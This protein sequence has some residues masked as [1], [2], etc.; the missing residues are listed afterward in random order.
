V[1]IPPAAGDGTTLRLVLA[2]PM[3]RV[4]KAPEMLVAAE[5][6]P[7]L[8]AYGSDLGIGAEREDPAKLRLGEIPPAARSAATFRR[9]L[10][11]SSTLGCSCASLN[12]T[13]CCNSGQ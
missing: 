13:L 1:E 2:M 5:L 8:I 11:F 9:P 12:S 10:R 6:K 4:V 7:L 3:R